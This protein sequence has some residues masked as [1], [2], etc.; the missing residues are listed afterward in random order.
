MNFEAEK[1]HYDQH[2]FVIVRQLLGDQEFAELKENLDRYIRD[3]VPTLPDARRL[4]S[5]S[6][7]PGD[8]QADAANGGRPLSFVSTLIIRSGRLWPRQ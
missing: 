8:A 7:P 2:G 1:Q 6:L 5:G 4:L 3:V